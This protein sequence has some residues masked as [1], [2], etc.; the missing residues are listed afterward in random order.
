MNFSNRLHPVDRSA[1]KRIGHEKSVTPAASNGSKLLETLF[2]SRGPFLQPGDVR[3]GTKEGLKAK[4]NT[5]DASV[6]AA[7][8]P[9]VSGAVQGQNYGVA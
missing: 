3:V 9:I 5:G 6:L 8:L 1:R 7:M 2:P 4:A